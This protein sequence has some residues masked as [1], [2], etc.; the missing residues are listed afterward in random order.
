MSR[1]EMYIEW[2]KLIGQ[3]VQ[4][5]KSITEW[6]KEHGVR[7]SRY[8]YW[9]K[10]VHKTLRTLKDICAAIESSGILPIGENAETIPSSTGSISGLMRVNLRSPVSS[11]PMCVD[12]D[13]ILPGA[14]SVPAMSVCIGAA[15]CEVYNGADTGTIERAFAVLAKIC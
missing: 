14:G 4:S 1:E 6:C 13:G 2:I 9:L 10:R 8:H 5:G 11:A 3:C 15:R 12:A 7:E